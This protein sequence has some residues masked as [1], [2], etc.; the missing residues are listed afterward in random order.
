MADHPP[1]VSHPNGCTTNNSSCTF[2]AVILGNHYIRPWYSSPYPKK[3]V[4]ETS[5]TSTKLYVCQ[6]CFKYTID[7]SKALQHSSVCTRLRTEPLGNRVYEHGRYAIYEVNGEEHTLFCQCL[8]LFAKFFLDTKSICYDVESFLFY[9]LVEYIPETTE[10][11]VVGFFSKEKQSW[12]DYNLA[13]ILVFPP[14]QR[15]GLGK[16]LISF[17]YE[18]SRME[19]KIGSP[20]KPLSDLGY[21]GY[22]TYWASVIARAVSKL[23]NKPLISINDLSNITYI[24]HD[25]IYAG[26]R[27]MDALVTHA[28]RTIV[29]SK[30]KVA[31]WLAKNKAAA[32]LNMVVEP[33]YVT[34]Y[35]A[36]T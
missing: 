1:P 6:Y 35:P 9:A 31:E 15:R 3:L 7:A 19:R 23:D 22:V 33:K 4:G 11:R 27:Y 34:I 21:K 12:D 28:N 20:E 30:V 17:S 24:H 10:R 32:S 25:D 16:L 14:Y 13:C 29:I 2:S 5:S 8:S 18:L 36:T 26:L